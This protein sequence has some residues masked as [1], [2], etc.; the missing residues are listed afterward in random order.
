M[1]DRLI[2]G[3]GAITDLADRIARAFTGRASGNVLGHRPGSLIVAA[4]LGV[5][6]VVLVLVGIEATD[7]PT[8]RTLDAATVATSQ[9]LGSR[10][11][12]TVTGG[13]SSNYVVTYQDD[14][15]NNL[16]IPARRQGLVLLPHGP[17]VPVRRDRALHPVAHRRV[18]CLGH[19]PGLR[20]R[21]V[22]Q[23]GS[24][25][26]RRGDRRAGPARRRRRGID[27][28][29]VPAG[30][31]ATLDL[32]A[33]LPANESA[34]AWAGSRVGTIAGVCSTD[35]NGNGACDREEYDLYDIIVYDPVSKNAITVVVAE[36]PEF[37]PG[38]FTGM[39]RRDERAVSDAK[40]AEGPAVRR[41]GHDAQRDLHP[42]RRQGAGERA[43]LLRRAALAA[44]LAVVIVVGLVGGY[45][46]FRRSV[47]G[48]EAG[49]DPR[50]RGADPAQGDRESPHEHRP[51]PCPGG[52]GRPGPLRRDTGPR[53][54]RHRGNAGVD[55]ADPGD[56]P[57][58]RHR[59]AGPSGLGVAAPAT[60]FDIPASASTL[61]VERRNK[62]EGVAV[63]LGELTSD[64]DRDRPAVPRQ[65]AGAQ[66][67]GRDR[68]A[69]AV[70]RRRSAD[71]ATESRP[72]GSTSPA[73]RRTFV[74]SRGPG[75]TDHPRAPDDGRLGARRHRGGRPP[76]A[77]ST[78][79]S[80]GCRTSR[81][82]CTSSRRAPSIRSRRI[83]R[84]SSTTSSRGGGRHGRCGGPA[85]RPRFAR[86]RRGARAT[87]LPRH[88]RTARDP[89]RLRSG[90]GDRGR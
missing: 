9:D 77:G 27:A 79:S 28:T 26:L 43:V 83:R 67:H 80:C 33:E 85:G 6:A 73:P 24:L 11:Y 16:R 56:P 88:H 34:V 65:P 90:R 44:L 23:G 2:S 7:N 40:S 81:S 48:P 86:V 53:G 10:T 51:G 20:G 15:D 72:S 71:A 37:Q 30:T 59:P 3:A 68:D 46:I 61:I 22:R 36:S 14:N 58:D 78:R 76:R 54:G 64:C 38:T 75:A 29:S 69:A 82:G 1:L 4:G 87:S 45:L 12:A 8:P 18:P 70:V 41:P 89:G 5:L 32:A 49:P 13:I 35:L 50:P 25:D 57:V 63:G 17:G 55:A 74:G 42:R 19:R 84:T 39:L 52:A 47:A 31:P 21:G 66:P 60:A 62:P